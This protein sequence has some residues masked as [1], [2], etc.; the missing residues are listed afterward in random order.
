MM[1]NIIIL[2]VIFIVIIISIN[3]IVFILMMERGFLNMKQ[4]SCLPAPDHFNLHPLMS[5]LGNHARSSRPFYVPVF[6]GSHGLFFYFAKRP[7]ASKQRFCGKKSVVV[8]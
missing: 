4:R 5:S 3:I 1:N 8:S 6:N 7:L 2:I